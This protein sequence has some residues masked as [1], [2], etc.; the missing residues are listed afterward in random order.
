MPARPHLLAADPVVSARVERFGVRVGQPPLLDP[1]ADRRPKRRPWQ[2]ADREQR[3][4][5]RQEFHAPQAI[6]RSLVEALREAGDDLTD[7]PAAS[8]VGDPGA[9]WKSYPSLAALLEDHRRFQGRPQNLEVVLRG[10]GAQLVTYLEL[11]EWTLGRRRSY[12]FHLK[13]ARQRRLV[14]GAVRQGIEAIREIE[15]DPRDPIASE[16]VW[17]RIRDAVNDEVLHRFLGQ[18]LF[19]AHL[20]KVPDLPLRSF[21]ELRVCVDEF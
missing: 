20:A 2:R 12:R 14:T 21:G 15:E 1:P 16:R 9:P 6:R 18:R 11:A 7:V 3:A 19:L 5:V 17:L 13:S 10:I 8:G 4:R